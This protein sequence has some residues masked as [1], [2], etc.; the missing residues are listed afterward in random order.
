MHWAH[1]N[2]VKSVQGG[3]EEGSLKGAFCSV[4]SEAGCL[5]NLND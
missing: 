1:S 3:T 4:F 5:N 2:K